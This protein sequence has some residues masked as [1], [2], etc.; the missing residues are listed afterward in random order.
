MVKVEKDYKIEFPKDLRKRMHIKPGDELKLLGD[1]NGS[2]III[3]KEV[4]S[5]TQQTFGIWK[6]EADGIEYMDKMR[7]R[8]KRQE[9]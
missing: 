1:K 8:W 3:K 9:S 5:V 7:Y 6:D 4:T 2:C